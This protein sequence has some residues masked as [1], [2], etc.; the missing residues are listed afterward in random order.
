M[1]HSKGTWT[2]APWRTVLAY[3][4]RLLFLIAKLVAQNLWCIRVPLSTCN[5]PGWHDMFPIL[6]FMVLFN[7]LF[8]FDCYWAGVIPNVLIHWPV[9]VGT[10]PPSAGLSPWNV[11]FYWSKCAGWLIETLGLERSFILMIFHIDITIGTSL[12]APC[13]LYLKGKQFTIV[14]I[15]I[16]QSP[17]VPLFF[18]VYLPWIVW[19]GMTSP[20]TWGM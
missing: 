16:L 14:F 7:E 2:P 18:F 4:V 13:W 20:E 10:I 8:T 9:F 15:G 5:P 11:S 3:M 6:V 1:E 19:N 17:M 12:V